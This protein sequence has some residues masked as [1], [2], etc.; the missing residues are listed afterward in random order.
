[1]YTLCKVTIYDIILY[2]KLVKESGYMAANDVITAYERLNHVLYRHGK[3]DMGQYNSGYNPEFREMEYQRLTKLAETQPEQTKEF[4]LNNEE[5]V[6]VM[7]A[8]L[9]KLSVEEQPRRREYTIKFGCCTEGN[10][11]ID[12][13]NLEFCANH[14]KEIVKSLMGYVC[15]MEI[16]FIKTDEICQMNESRILDVSVAVRFTH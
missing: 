3:S 12:N 1:M 16:S 10:S 8:N 13:I 2:I 5:K 15:M 4:L 6:L 14:W 9:L 7:I 11:D